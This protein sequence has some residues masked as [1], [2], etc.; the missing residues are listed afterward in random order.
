MLD[1]AIGIV[2][3]LVIGCFYPSLLQKV[4]TIC[5][6]LTHECDSEKKK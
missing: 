3:G 2:I 6:N 1:L 5:N 4:K